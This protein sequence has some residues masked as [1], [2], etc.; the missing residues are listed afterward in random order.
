MPVTPPKTGRNTATLTI[1]EVLQ[2]TRA[3]LQERGCDTPRL[4]AEVL[5]AHTLS[6]ERLNLYLEH[7][8]PLSTEEAD[9][10]R[11]LVR[12][13]ARREPVAYITGRR[14]FWSLSLAVGPGVLIPR[15][16]TE[17]LVQAALDAAAALGGDEPPRILDVGTGSG[18]VALALAHELAQARVLA[19]DVSE[20][21][22]AFARLNAEA[23]GLDEHVELRPG[24]LTAGLEALPPFDLV[25]TNPPYV[26]EADWEG[27]AP[28]IREHEPRDALDGGPGG[29]RV[30]A[31]LAAEAPAVLRGGG[32]LFTEIG[33]GQREGVEA[34]FRRAGG[35]RFLGIHRDLAGCERVLEFERVAG[36]EGSEKN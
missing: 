10:Y 9:S 19:V 15:P 28:E 34:L 18:A 7:D 33:Q 31:R 25:V 8:K 13:R 32:R 14:E 35:W 5:L 16:E 22:L 23:L 17:T 20:E 11:D 26:D 6:T 30:L 21:A 4:D 36:E 3:Y 27:L 29:L 2:R 1:G 12:R 24:D